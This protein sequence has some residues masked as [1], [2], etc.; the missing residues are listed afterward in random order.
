MSYLTKIKIKTGLGAS[1]LFVCTLSL[2]LI[3]CT[4]K[5]TQLVF[6]GATMGTSYHIKLV[7]NGVSAT[8]DL[9]A[10][11][12]NRLIELNKTFSTYQSDSELM[13]FNRQ[14]INKVSS[15]S[16]DMLQVMLMAEAVYELTEGA[17]DP[18]VGPLV[19]LWG[20]GPEN[21]GDTIPDSSQI[22]R[23]LTMVGM[24]KLVINSEEKTA[25]RL[26]EIQLDF[27]AIAKGYAVDAVAQELEQ[28]GFHNFLVEVGGELL[29]RGYKSNGQAWRIA[30]ENPSS[31]HNGVQQAIALENIS[32]ATSGDYRN[33]FENNGQRYSHTIDPKTGYP[34]RDPM[35]SV[36]V[37]A[38]STAEA[39]ALATAMMV[40][41]SEK[42]LLLAER[43]NIPVYLLTHQSEVEYSSA[44]APYLKEE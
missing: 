4:E 30:I 29:A 35:I 39:D 24:D 37:L 16:Q 21:T 32:I 9:A 1:F 5:P 15:V 23:Y 34:V 31:Q 25:K 19:N 41:G 20:F 11:I 27:S 13:R 18:T 8:K 22:S 17:F 7:P 10:I 38:N 36:T 42:A 26:S 2:L 44:F 3:G 6:N 14:A 12:K 33:F 43:Q 40:L 28:K